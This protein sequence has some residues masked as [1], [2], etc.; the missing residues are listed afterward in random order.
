MKIAG[1]LIV[2]VAMAGCG[3]VANTPKPTPI[4]DS[5]RKD[6]HT[7]GKGPNSGVVFDLGKYHAEFT[8]DHDK[9]ECTVF[10]LGNDEKTPM[11]V[12]AKDLSLNTKETKT[13]GGKAVP[14]MTIKLL[15]KGESDGK[16]S[17]FV[18][19]DPGLGNDANFEGTIFG[20]IEGKP[21]QGQFKE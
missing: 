20:E 8:V 10:L 12:V 4:K 5:A 6:A 11:A 21:S 14:P 18:G 1:I 17:K 2:V 7:H 13:K 15:P 3:K 9:K 16:A 19:A